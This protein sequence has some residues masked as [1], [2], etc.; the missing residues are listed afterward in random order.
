MRALTYT[1]YGTDELPVKP[2]ATAQQKVPA[3]AYEMLN[4]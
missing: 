3:I 4:S 1:D 2:A